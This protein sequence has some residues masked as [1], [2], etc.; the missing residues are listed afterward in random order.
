MLFLVSIDDILSMFLPQGRKQNDEKEPAEIF[1][2]IFHFTTEYLMKI[3]KSCI[4]CN[5]FYALSNQILAVFLLLLVLSVQLKLLIVFARMIFFTELI[6]RNKETIDKFQQQMIKC[7]CLMYTLLQ[8]NKKCKCRLFSMQH[9][10]SICT[11]MLC[12]LLT[13]SDVFLPI[14]S[15]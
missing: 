13:V 12:V 9:H 4:Q 7:T 14:S 10:W 5:V 3:Y 1:K 11:S 6:N 8:I 2:N 15:T